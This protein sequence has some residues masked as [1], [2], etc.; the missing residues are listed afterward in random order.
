MDLKPWAFT[1]G[2]STWAATL[3]WPRRLLRNLRQVPDRA[4]CPEALS[5]AD[6]RRARRNGGSGSGGKRVSRTRRALAAGR[7]AE[8]VT[9]SQ[10][11]TPEV[12]AKASFREFY[13]DITRRLEQSGM[14]EASF[15]SITDMSVWVTATRRGTRSGEVFNRI[16]SG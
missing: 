9:E 5:G 6:N 11:N 8:A 1:T 14:G 10:G 15:F 12:A 13:N 3:C 16:R 7:R 4:A 2:S